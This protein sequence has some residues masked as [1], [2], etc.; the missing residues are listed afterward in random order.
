MCYTDVIHSRCDTFLFQQPGCRPCGDTHTRTHTSLS[1][2]SIVTETYGRSVN[3]CS[4]YGLSRLWYALWPHLTAIV[5]AAAGDGGGDDDADN[6]VDDDAISVN[7]VEHQLQSPPCP[8]LP[9]KRHD[10]IGAICWK[11]HFVIARKSRKRRGLVRELGVIGFYIISCRYQFI[12][13]RLTV[14]DGCCTGLECES[15]RIYLNLTL[16]SGQETK[17]LRLLKMIRHHCFSVN[18]R[19]YFLYSSRVAFLATVT[20][21]SVYR[22][23]QKVSCCI[24]GSNF[25]NYAPI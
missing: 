24:A 17:M 9:S 8:P 19:Y 16:R 3:A 25:V 4:K 18:V 10:L 1:A 22:V 7:V 6:N 11:C 13:C 21:I 23:G 5:A 12:M 20:L 15:A 2:K 14:S